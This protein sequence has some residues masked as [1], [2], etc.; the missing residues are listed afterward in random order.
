MWNNYFSP[1]HT[2]VIIDFFFKILNQD[3]PTGFET[4]VEI[5]SIVYDAHLLSRSELFSFYKRIKQAGTSFFINRG[6]RQPIPF[7]RLNE[8]VSFS[9]GA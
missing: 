7:I 5:T 1:H 9:G 4:F 6:A 2:V 3:T 8:R